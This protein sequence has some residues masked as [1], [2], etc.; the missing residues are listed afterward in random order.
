M[1]HINHRRG[2][3]RRSVNREV[4]CSCQMCRNPRHSTWYDNPRTRAERIFDLSA[5]EAI[6]EYFDELD[7]ESG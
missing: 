1:P 7:S 3:T 2:E 4:R 6:A 5:D